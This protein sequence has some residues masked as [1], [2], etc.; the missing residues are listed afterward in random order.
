MK[1]ICVTFSNTKEIRTL[2]F[3]ASKRDILHMT[4]E[5]LCI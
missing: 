3:S 5:D 1:Y 2:K 4:F